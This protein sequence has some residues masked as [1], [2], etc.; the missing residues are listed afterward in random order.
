MRNLSRGI[1]FFLVLMIAIPTV[2]S[3]DSFDINNEQPP[4]IAQEQ[5]DSATVRVI[6]NEA[7]VGSQHIILVTGLNA[8]ESISIRITQVTNDV[9][10]YT[11]TGV[12]DDRGILEVEIFT[13][14]DDTAGTYLVEVFNASETVIGSAELE[15]LEA[16]VYTP[17]IMVTPLQGEAGTIFTIEIVGAEPF[18]L[19]DI[20]IDNEAREEIFEQE[21]RTNVDGDVTV[22]FISDRDTLGT[23][24]LTI[25]AEAETIFTQEIT[26]VAQ[27][28]QGIVEATPDAIL[29]AE[30]VFIT[31]SGASP[32][33]AL[34]VDV[35]FD[36]GVIDSLDVT[37]N[38]S[39]LA[40]FEYT[41]P[42]DGER[43]DYDIFVY[44]VDELIAETTVLVDILPVSTTVTPTVG[45]V[46]TVFFVSVADLRP[47]EAITVQLLRDGDIV[48]SRETTADA[49]GIGRVPLGQRIDLELGTYSVEVIRLG[50]VVST[51]SVEIADERPATPQVINPDD[52]SLTID[53]LTGLVPTIYTITVEGLPADQNITLFV[54]RDG[55]SVFSTGATADENG[56][57]TTELTSEPTDPPG[58]YT[59][60]IRA[61]GNVIASS[62]FEIADATE[63]S[64]S[65]DEDTSE[66]DEQTEDEVVPPVESD[67]TLDIQPSTLRQG[68]RIEFILRDLE[69]DEVVLFEL[70]FQDEII[71]R[72]EPMA[73][74]NGVATVALIARED[75][76]LGDYEVRILRQGEV[77]VVDGFTIVTQ[78][79]VIDNAQVVVEPTSGAQGT[80]Y[81]ITVTDLMP[82]EVVT[83][84]VNIDDAVVFED[85]RIAN[86]NGT[87]SV[88]LNSDVTDALGVYDVTITRADSDTLT[89]T[90]EITDGEDVAVQ[91]D[92]DGD[93]VTITIDPTSGEIGTEHIV[94]VTGLEPNETFTLTIEFDGEVVYTVERNAD[95]NGTFET[96]IAAAEGDEAGDYEVI[97]DRTD[98]DD[99]TG[100]LTILG[101]ESVVSSEISIEIDPSEVVD[102][103]PFDVIVSGLEPNESVN[104]QIEYDGDV[105]F[106]VDREADDNGQVI[107]NLATDPSDPLG[108][109]TIIV[110]RGDEVVSGDVEIIAEIADGVS[111]SSSPS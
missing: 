13:E 49:D 27:T 47:D 3:S 108:I 84:T 58:T 63:T 66:Q 101:D 64:D 32:E 100:I 35:V 82:D 25:V 37:S 106:E 34:R 67:V 72:A 23:L 30:T 104:I 98:A 76:T 4:T 89:S 1:F 45:T 50:E 92:D 38:I 109:Y 54:L 70:R 105:V 110:T 60:E 103:E 56:V 77:I 73:D 6:P 74:D 42:D 75:E 2:A 62:D 78:D 79:A 71:Y 55:E 20:E 53:P 9:V 33:T 59:I 18:L 57:Y 29:P 97:I 81:T 87:V 10:V 111:V 83:I 39:G 86:E 7:R 26:V 99:I 36:D 22:E 93:R 85:E 17:E 94:T 102:G 61:E 95:E 28:L 65:E 51:T 19:L 52:I 107:L 96:V 40:I 43:G 21:A 24:V 12:A 41:F 31:I 88:T 80:E 69:P 44:E 46:G 15:I 11:T 16:E 48:Q 90:L 8:S 5:S 91:P 14:V 68:E